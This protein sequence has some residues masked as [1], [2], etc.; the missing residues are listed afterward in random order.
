MSTV[1][2]ECERYSFV[3]NDQVPVHF[4]AWHKL[5]LG[6][7]EPRI[8]HMSPPGTDAVH[9]GPGGAIILWDQSRGASEYFIVER[10]RPNSPGLR[11]DSGVAGDG[12]LIWRVQQGVLNGVGHMS[13]PNFAFGGSN[14]WRPGQQTPMLK[15]ADGS[16]TN[17]YLSIAADTAGS[18]RISWGD[19]LVHASSAKHLQLFHGGNGVTPVD[20]GLPMQGIFYGITSSGI[21][22][23]NSYNGRGEDVDDPVTRKTGIRTPITQLGTTGA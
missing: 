4:D 7:V 5:S 17:I 21:L 11:Y 14:V 16:P 15:W 10:R 22:D 18:I 12:V 20:S 8:Y 2:N 6:W 3:S 23:W 1:P 19:Q 9:E 13:A